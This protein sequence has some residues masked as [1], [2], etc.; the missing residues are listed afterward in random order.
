[1]VLKSRRFTLFD[2]LYGQYALEPRP[3]EEVPDPG[4]SSVIIPV[5]QVSD[6]Y[7]LAV[8]IQALNLDISIGNVVV[9]QTVPVGERWHLAHFTKPAT[10]VNSAI[11]LV[12]P[13][14]GIDDLD[15]NLNLTQVDQV[16]TVLLNEVSHIRLEEGWRIG[17]TSTDNVG[18]IA[19][20]LRFSVYRERL[21]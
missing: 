14:G 18:D 21:T 12:L 1:M 5:F 17:M 4:V 7:Q 15:D 2:Q 6:L 19:R 11:T 9:A 20:V 8:F 3:A 13:G 16:T 10:S